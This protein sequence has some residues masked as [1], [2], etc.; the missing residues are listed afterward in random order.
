MAEDHRP[1]KRW[2]G[3]VRIAVAVGISAGLWV[4]TAGLIYVLARTF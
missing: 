4:V 2:P 1:L 3:A